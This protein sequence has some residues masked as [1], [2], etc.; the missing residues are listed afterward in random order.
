MQVTLHSGKRNKMDAFFKIAGLMLLSGLKFFLAPT[1]TVLAGFS[2]WETVL[3][4]TTGGA[5]GFLVFF[6][7]GILLSVWFQKRF[8]RKKK[9]LF[10]KK[11]RFIVRIKSSSGRI[12]IALLTPCLISIPIGAIISA[13]YF[14]K[15]KGT[16]L[17]NIVSVVLWSFILTYVTL[18]V[19]S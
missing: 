5:I 9:S 7:F 17:I 11:N 6:R 10:N 13:N 15:Q 12:G 2:F 16:V 3:I 4:T 14:S 19:K 8:Q 18:Y 1:S